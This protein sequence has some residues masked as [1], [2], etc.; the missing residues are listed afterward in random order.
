MNAISASAVALASLTLAGLFDG[1]LAS[2]G[3]ATPRPVDFL[4]SLV[5]MI[6]AYLWFRHDKQRMGYQ[7]STL[8]GGMIIFIS[9]VSIPVYLFRSRPKGRRAKPI[10]KFIGL[11]VSGILLSGLAP[12]VFSR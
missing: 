8:L 4:L 3:M 6:T 2:K 11:L 7:A 1:Y 5:L 12:L 9:I 10:L